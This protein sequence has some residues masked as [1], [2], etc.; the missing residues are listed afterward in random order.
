MKNTRKFMAAVMALAMVSALAP[1][2]VFA[3]SKEID[4]T[5]TKAPT[6]DA[7]YLV[8]IPATLNVENSGWNALG[9]G[10]KVEKAPKEGSTTEYLDFTPSKKVTVS[11]SSENS[12]KLTSNENTETVGYTLKSASTDTAAVTTWDF[13]ADQITKAGTT[14]TAGIDVNATDYEA[15]PAGTYTDK[16]TFTISV[17]DAVTITYKKIGSAIDTPQSLPA[18]FT[19]VT[20]E[21]ATAYGQSYT[22][23][24]AWLIIYAKDG[25][26]YKFVCS[27]PDM[28]L[29]NGTQTWDN[30][31]YG[32][33]GCYYDP[34][35]VSIL[36]PVAE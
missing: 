5:L 12:W 30:I 32:E 14:K 22:E 16:I 20:L 17:E 19:E 11:A 6:D 33:S 26:K 36:A 7:L 31:V 1:M 2:S 15:A 23:T 27:S 24:M 13:S 18:N 8:T 28:P 21:E 3:E 9:T 29:H 25:D 10:I 4:V 35:Q 34:E